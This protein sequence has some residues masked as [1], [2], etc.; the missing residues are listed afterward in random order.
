[1]TAGAEDLFRRYAKE[2]NWAVRQAA[3]LLPDRAAI[4]L[5]DIRQE[6][7]I[8]LATYAG[9]MPGHHAGRLAEWETLGDDL[10]VRRYLCAT[11]RAD[12]VQLVG[13][14]IAP[15][16]PLPLGE[17]GADAGPSVS[18]EDALADDLSLAEG[19]RASYPCLCATVLDGMTEVQIAHE[20]GVTR[21]TVINR[22]A[23]ER[24]A[25]ALASHAALCTRFANLRGAREI[26]GWHCLTLSPRLPWAI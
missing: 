2:I 15:E 24:A 23:A 25:F 17:L 19:L 14:R 21:H 16:S 26:P 12:L 1:V 9:L 11:L 8:C 20:A 4:D 7:F 22:L 18:F 10:A 5:D 13:R 3:R 6:A